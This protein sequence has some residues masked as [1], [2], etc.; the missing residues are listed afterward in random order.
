MAGPVDKDDDVFQDNSRE[1][2]GVIIMHVYGMRLNEV[3]W[4]PTVTMGRTL[5]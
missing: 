4:Q 5:E 3:E 2:A 1:D